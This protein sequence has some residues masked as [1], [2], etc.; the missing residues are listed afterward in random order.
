MYVD[1]S[2]LEKQVTDDWNLRLKKYYL[3]GIFNGGKFQYI[4]LNTCSE[5][6]FVHAQFHISHIPETVRYPP[7][8]IWIEFNLADD[9]FWPPTI[10]VN[11][12]RHFITLTI[13][14]ISIKYIKNCLPIRVQLQLGFRKKFVAT[15]V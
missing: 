6:S 15:D 5:T 12:L 9:L 2:G 14:K 11:L 1:D 3:A 10:N 4:S 13:W 8:F 7:N